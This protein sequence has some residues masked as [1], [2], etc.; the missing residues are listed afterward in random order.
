MDVW[1]NGNTQTC[2]HGCT[3]ARAHAREAQLSSRVRCRYCFHT[4]GQTSSRI[5]VE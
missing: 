4:P 2:M 5:H 3:H 1:D